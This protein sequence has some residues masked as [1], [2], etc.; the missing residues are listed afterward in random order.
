M[1]ARLKRRQGKELLPRFADAAAA[2]GPARARDT[3]DCPTAGAIWT[4]VTE[5]KLLVVRYLSNGP[6]GFNELMR[7]SG[8]NSKTLSSTLKFLEGKE[9]VVRRVLSTRPFSVEYSLSASGEELRPVLEELGKWG[10][11][12]L[13]QSRAEALPLPTR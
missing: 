5:P 2:S 13:P 4:M 3:W 9:V 1:G 12:W 11:K 7:A 8:I 10:E 6:K